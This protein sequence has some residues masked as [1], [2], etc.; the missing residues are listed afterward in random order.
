MQ[1]F[2]HVLLFPV[3]CF[4]CLFDKDIEPGLGG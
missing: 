1:L 2:N 3:R 4:R